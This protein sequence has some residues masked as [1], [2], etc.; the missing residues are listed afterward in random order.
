MM[1]LIVCVATLIVLVNLSV[2][3]QQ[4]GISTGGSAGTYFAIGKELSRVAKQ[5]GVRLRVLNSQGSVENLYR[6]LKSP[7]TQL[8]IVQHDALFWMEA[9]ANPIAK[10]ISQKTRMILPLYNEEV[11]ILA[12]SDENIT[13][14]EDLA[15]KTVAMGKPGSGTSVTAETLFRIAGIKP[16]RRSDLGGKSALGELKQGNIDAMFYVAGAPVKL[17]VDS[18]S[19]SDNLNFV[20]VN[21]KDILDIYQINTILDHYD[22]TKDAV[23]TVAVK[24]ILV[25]YDYLKGGRKCKFVENVARSLWR[26]L[27]DLKENGHPKWKVVDLNAKIKG[28][29]ESRCVEDLKGRQADSPPSSFQIFLDSI[30]R[31]Q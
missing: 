30:K 15:G 2:A 29:L 17:F 14:F 3:A 5:R 16:G 11:H 1:R 8:A 27:D 31:A 24:A 10:R 9:Q 6:I 25:T 22:W 28:V 23:R 12:R 19:P 20:N 7:D 13:E 26:T 4:Y 18:V 21:N